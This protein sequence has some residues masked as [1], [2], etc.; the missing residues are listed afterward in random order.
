MIYAD[1]AATSAMSKAA[2]NAMLPYFSELFSNPSA[3]YG[4]GTEA[5]RAVETARETIASCINAKPEQV[6]FTSC[7]T[8]SNNWVLRCAGIQKKSRVIVTS[9]IEHHAVLNTC[10]ALASCGT[11]IRYLPVDGNGVV[12]ATKIDDILKDADLVSVMTANNEIGTIEPIESLARTAHS[13]GALFHS[14]AVQAVGHIPVDVQRMQV[15][16]LSA[17]AHK[18]NGPKGI[19]FLFVREPEQF[20]PLLYGGGQEFGLRSGTE[21]VPAIVGMAAALQENCASMKRSTAHVNTLSYI[22]VNIL[23]DSIPGVR[24]NGADQR[25]PGSISVAI[26]G[27]KAEAMLHYL[28]L[29][30]IC[31]SS[32]SACNSRSTQISHVL[33]AIGSPDDLSLGTLRITF[34]AENTEEDAKQVAGYIV[35][36]YE[37]LIGKRKIGT[38]L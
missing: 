14:D 3:L 34:G 22:V 6:I 1:H 29:H 20:S 18:F 35:K 17:S 23:S 13:A 15:D 31:I 25:I 4:A 28:D 30:G 36:G 8:E 21:N 9:P 38:E 10:R 24:F 11:E 37:K 2:I 33:Q 26:P 27:I 5:R 12:K 16:F 7:G 32:G 19:G